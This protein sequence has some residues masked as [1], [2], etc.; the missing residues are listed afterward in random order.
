MAWRYEPQY[1]PDYKDP[2]S[3]PEDVKPWIRGEQYVWDGTEH[4]PDFKKV[5]THFLRFT[6]DFMLF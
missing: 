2:A 5:F 4:L 1:D 3:V 6:D